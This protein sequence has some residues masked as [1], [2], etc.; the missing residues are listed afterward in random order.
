MQKPVLE[1][2]TTVLIVAV[3]I[4]SAVFV[5]SRVG[6]RWISGVIKVSYHHRNSQINLNPKMTQR[7]GLNL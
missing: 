3:L 2:F 5:A 1:Q 6:C 7:E 4:S